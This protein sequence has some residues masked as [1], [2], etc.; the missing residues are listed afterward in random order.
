VE[1]KK[2]RHFA[3][4]GG[5]MVTISSDMSHGASRVARLKWTVN[6]VSPDTAKPRNTASSES[7][8]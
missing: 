3:Q 6:P 7:L 5:T 2:V 1:E 8:F 4:F